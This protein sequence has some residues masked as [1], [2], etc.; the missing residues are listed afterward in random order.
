MSLLIDNNVTKQVLDM[1]SAIEA[2]EDAFTQLGDGKATFQGR[3]DIVSPTASEGDCYAWGSMLG[4]IRSPP[5]LAFRFKSDVL[6]WFEQDGNLV[7]RKFNVEPGTFMGFVLLFDTTNGELLALINDGELQHVRVGATAGVACKYLSREDAATVGILGSGG[8]A[9]SY[10]QAFDAVRELEEITVYSPTP[11]HREQFAD[12]IREE[13]G[14]TVTTADS[15][16]AA[17]RGKD[18]VAVCT[19]SRNTVFEAD[20]L[21]EGMFLTNT[22]TV[23]IDGDLFERDE[24]VYTTTTEP[25]LDYVIEDDDLTKERYRNNRGARGFEQLEY[26]TLGELLT[27]QTLR[28]QNPHQA[29]FYHNMSSA[30]QF[31]AVGDVIYQ[32]AVEQGLGTPIPLYWFQ[33]NIRN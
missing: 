20:W 27:D 9:R 15:E 16:R 17:V 33:Q 26:P 11:D 6:Q 28:R 14:V 10:V 12:E 24:D 22:T 32:R 25:F 7:E 21:E 1:D 19:D 23:E 31:A 18:I 3:T 2:I 13:L 29:I 4:A 30:I 5:R 8:M